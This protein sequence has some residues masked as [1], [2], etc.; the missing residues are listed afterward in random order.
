MGMTLWLAAV[1]IAINGITAVVFNSITLGWLFF[2]LAGAVVTV[3]EWRSASSI[4]V[5]PEP[6]PIGLDPVH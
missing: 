4:A 5:A 6:I 2:W 3:S 1:G